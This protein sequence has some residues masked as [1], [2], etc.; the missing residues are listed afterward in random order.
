ML[1][2]G[3]LVLISLL[4][5]PLYLA[6]PKGTLRFDDVLLALTEARKVLRAT[7][8]VEC[9]KKAEIKVSQ[10]ERCRGQSPGTAP[11]C[12]LS[13]RTH[14]DSTEFLQQ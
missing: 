7:F 2:C 3:C 9:S 6:V 5:V 1:F 4:C 11:G 13:K 8:T 10:G 14:M 12:V